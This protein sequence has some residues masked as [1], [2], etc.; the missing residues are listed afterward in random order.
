M[1]GGVCVCGGG[2]CGWGVCMVGGMHGGGGECMVG[3]HAW[4]GGAC[5]TSTSPPASRQ[6]GYSIRSMSGRYASYWNAFLFQISCPKMLC[7][8]MSTNDPS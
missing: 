3:G 1:H 8:V 6:N 5:V 4:L 7:Q 2:M